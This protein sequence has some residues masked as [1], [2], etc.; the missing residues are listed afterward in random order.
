MPFSSSK[1][2]QAL[3]EEGRLLFASECKFFLGIQDL[4]QLGEGQLPEI[5]FSG[6]SNVGKSSLLNALAGQNFLA[7]TSSRPGRT[8]QLNFF[9]LANRLVLVDMPGY[10][11][12]EASKKVKESW[13]NTM[14][15]FLRARPVLKRVLLLLDA[16]IEVKQNDLQMIDLLNR[17][18]VSFQVILTKCDS[19]SQPAL[20]AKT[21][22]VNK[23]VAKQPAAYPHI[24][25]TSSKSGQGIDELRAQLAQL[26]IPRL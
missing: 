2:E 1:E 6:R 10:G 15:T 13:Q 25:L 5:A 7:R 8:Q 24:M 19:L 21:G 22:E 18:A 9:S 16:R 26:A 17:A 23:I 4:K 12:A 14:F 3:L 11:Y 20:V